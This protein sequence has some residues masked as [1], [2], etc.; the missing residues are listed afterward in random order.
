V[1]ENLKE[2]QVIKREFENNKQTF[3]RKKIKEYIMEASEQINKQIA[4]EVK[5]KVPSIM[6]D[7]TSRHGKHVFSASLRYAK[8]TDIV[9]RTIGLLSQPTNKKMIILK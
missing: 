8:G 6:F 4:E 7:S 9:E 5:D 3:S 2:A 1:A